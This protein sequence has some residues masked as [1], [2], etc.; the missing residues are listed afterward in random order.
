[1]EKRVIY[2]T[3]CDRN[4]EVLLRDGGEPELAGAVCLEVGWRCTG[5]SCPIC[6]VP[7]GRAGEMENETEEELA[8]A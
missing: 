2:C 7:A 4:V 6:A 5:T 1:M 3:G 8:V